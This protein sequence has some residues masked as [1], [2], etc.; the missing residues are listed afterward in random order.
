MNNALAYQQ[1]VPLNVNLLKR[2]GREID[3]LIEQGVAEQAQLSKLYPNVRITLCSEDEMGSREPYQSYEHYD[4]HL[5][6]RQASGCL[7]LTYFPEASSGLVVALH[8]M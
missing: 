1:G 8:E 2:I 4:L 5:Y 6:A 7:T 3:G